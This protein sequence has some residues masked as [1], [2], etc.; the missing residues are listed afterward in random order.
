MRLRIDR[1]YRRLPAATARWRATAAHA[2][3]KCVAAAR[4]AESPLA[5]LVEVDFILVSDRTIAKVHGDFL[6]DPT[7]TDVITFHHGEILIS[8]DT[9]E[10]QAAEHGE[11]YEREV[12]RYMVHGLLHLAGWS[13]HDPAERAEMHRIQEEIL[14]AVWP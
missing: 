3:P 10:R 11:D 14:D 5:Q 7:P 1:R 2:V 4:E 6:D 13:D 8:L 12:A 9:A